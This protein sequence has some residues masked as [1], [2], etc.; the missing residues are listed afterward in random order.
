MTLL[1]KIIDDPEQEVLKR[2]RPEGEGASLP[3]QKALALIPPNWN[4]STGTH[5][6]PTMLVPRTRTRT[7]C[8]HPVN[9]LHTLGNDHSPTT[10]HDRCVFEVIDLELNELE[11]D[12]PLITNTKMLKPS[13]QHL[14]ERQREKPCVMLRLNDENTDR[15]FETEVLIDPA[16]YQTN[17]SSN[18][19]VILSY[20]SSKLASKIDLITNTL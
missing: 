17:G 13:V 7:V 16:S 14:S 9:E 20:V 4:T 3:F 6:F 8:C 12:Q 15:C 18:Q 1:R 5:A 11:H 2:D 19:D 10:K